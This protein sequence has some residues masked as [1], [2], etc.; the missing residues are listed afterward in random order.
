MNIEEI[1]SQY[2]MKDILKR[3]DIQVDRHGFCNCPLHNG[4]HTA[5]MK[6]YDKDFYCFGCGAGGDFITFVEL[7]QNLSF[8]EACEWISGE[9]LTSKTRTQLAIARIERQQKEKAA[10]QMRED[11]KRINSSFTG[12]WQKILRAEPFSDEWAKAYNKWQM[13]CYQ[14]EQLLTQL[15]AI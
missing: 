2:S 1:K 10:K 7:Y 3:C 5:S 6:V 12:L 4:D 14:Q 11:L 8:K 15:G 13:L 9:H